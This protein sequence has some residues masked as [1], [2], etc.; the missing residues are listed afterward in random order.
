MAGTDPSAGPPPL[1]HAIA[2]P[3]ETEGDTFPALVRALFEACGGDLALHLRCPRASGRRLW[4]LASAV[5]RVATSRGGWCVVNG[6]PDVALAAGAQAVQAGRRAIPL[7][8]VARLVAGRLRVGAS[9]H[10]A[11]EALRAVGDGADFLLLG[12]IYDTPSHPGRAGAGPG[13]VAESRRAL[14]TAGVGRAPLLAIGGID[15]SDVRAVRGA[16]A[17]GVAV[18]RAVWAAAD[19]PRAAAALVAALRA[20]GGTAAG[21]KSRSGEDGGG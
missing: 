5:S 21:P 7:A 14:A 18:R 8:E 3:E 4:E 2:G 11:A 12:T 1:L 17:D 13:L 16:G 20:A 6:R 15:V 19:P 9:V 10:S